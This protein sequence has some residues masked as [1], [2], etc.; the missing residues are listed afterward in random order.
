MPLDSHRTTIAV[1]LDIDVSKHKVY[2]AK[3]N[4]LEMIEGNEANQYAKMRDYCSLILRT[5]PGSVVKITTEPTPIENVRRF[6]R[7]FICYSAMKMGFKEGCRPLI[8]VDGCFLK[9]PYGGHLLSAVSTDG[10]NLMFLVAYAVVEVETRDSWEWFMGELM[11]AVGPYYVSMFVVL[12][13]IQGLVDTFEN[14]LQGSNHRK[15]LKNTEGLPL[16]FKGQQLKIEL[17][18]AARACTEADFEQHM[19]NIRQINVEAHDWLRKVPP[20]LWS[21]SA[22]NFTS[23][24]DVVINNM[25]ESWNSVILEVRDKPIMYML[26]WIRRH[27]MLRFQVKREWMES[28]AGLLCPEIQKQLNKVKQAARNCKVHYA[29]ENKYEVQCYGISEVVDLN[30]RSCSCRVWSLTG[31]PCKH[32]L[33]CI[34]TKRDQSEAYVDQFYQRETYLRSYAGLIMPIPMRRLTKIDLINP[35]LPPYFRKP[36]GRPKKVRNKKNDDPKSSTKLSRS[37]ESLKCSKC[38]ENGHNSRTCILPEALVIEKPPPRR[39]GRPPILGRGRGIAR[40]EVAGIGDGE[41]AVKGR[42]RGRPRRGGRA[43][44]S[45]VPSMVPSNQE[46]QNIRMSQLESTQASSFGY[47]N[48][49]CL[50]VDNDFL[51]I[52]TNSHVLIV[53]VG[54]CFFADVDGSQLLLEVPFFASVDGS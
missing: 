40:G 23:K 38:K 48:F 45:E 50:E 18:E 27:L 22:F 20:H 21:K 19:R 32:A 2:R 37:K 5:N 51:E 29:G 33:T 12:F 9:G 49:C 52:T 15:S 16:R 43:R 28:Q 30:H 31:I 4:A 11:D 17:W 47:C 8:G 7:V 34:F 44:G 25:C 1:D 42:D 10:N 41:V 24:N 46:V 54:G 3:R 53:A 14:I 36:T 6:Q 39:G 26:E 13:V 35:L